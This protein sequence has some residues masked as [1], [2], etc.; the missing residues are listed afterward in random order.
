MAPNSAPSAQIAPSGALCV[1][2]TWVRCESSPVSVCC[3]CAGCVRTVPVV[4]CL[5]PGLLVM[6]G[7][8]AALHMPWRDC[9]VPDTISF[10]RWSGWSQACPWKRSPAQ[11]RQR[12]RRRQRGG[13]SMRLVAHLAV[14]VVA[15]HDASVHII[16][17]G[18]VSLRSRGNCGRPVHVG[19]K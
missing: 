4:A 1:T 12:G 3:P 8:V 9:F 13:D 17:C 11:R 15:V 19:C 5:P 14:V 7:S 10:L 18:D 6:H 16:R 2:N